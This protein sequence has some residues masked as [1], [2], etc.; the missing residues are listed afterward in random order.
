MSP[1]NEDAAVRYEAC[2]QAAIRWLIDRP[3]Q[4]GFLNTKV[5]SITGVDYDTSSG[6]RGPQFTYGWIQGRGLEALVTFADFY[7]DLDP[8]LSQ[9]ISKRAEQLFQR[10]RELYLRDGH[11]YFLYDEEL[12][13]VIPSDDG[14]ASQTT[15]IP[16]FTYSD[17]FIAK[18]LVA[19]ACRF[20]LEN[21]GPFL[22]Y[23]H[24][25]IAAIEDG[26]F[27]M[28]E[29]RALSLENAK[30]EPND[31][32]PRMI[33]LG[34]AGLLHRCNHS[35]EAGFADQFIDDVLA[36]YYDASSGLLL[37]IPKQDA[38]NVGHGIEFC[39]FA[40]EHLEQHPN[41]SRIELLGEILRRSL[42]TGLQG[43]GI[44]L[45]L[46]SKTGQANSRY[47]PWWQMPEAIR[48]TAIGYKL[49]GDES[50]INLW[51]KA[52]A[53]FF[54]NY[55]QSER[56]FAYQTRTKEGPIDYVPATPDLDPGYH[57]GLSLL[58]AI[59]AIQD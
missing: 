22:D 6:L 3:N 38:C 28:E 18:G 39:G 51:Q 45:S 59:R 4:N 56:G 10:L 8:A 36:R 47:Y 58:A 46:S 53:A 13:P 11:S 24:N 29:K 30:A 27:Q 20:D 34:A 43:P 14:L 21:V 33:L 48:A 7:H 41:D 40:F 49:I 35:D 5:N 31:F 55:W 1:W 26:R 37:N 52:D 44:A 42:E 32:G 9:R 2:N 16:I 25:V 57:T 54:N 19:A 17:A 23:L 12:K 15:E 50:L